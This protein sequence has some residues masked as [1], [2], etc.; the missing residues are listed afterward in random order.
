METASELSTEQL[1]CR[2]GSDLETLAGR[3]LSFRAPTE[4]VAVIDA[5]VRLRAQLDS[6]IAMTV[7]EVDRFGIAKDLGYRTVA[8]MV[9]DH[10]GADPKETRA[11]VRLGRWVDDFEIFAAAWAGVST[12]FRG[13]Q[14]A[15]WLL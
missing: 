13:G 8:Q 5:G 10:T 1:L 7:A 4:L 14:A 15:V 6:L 9:G 3:G 12:D 2:V 11:D